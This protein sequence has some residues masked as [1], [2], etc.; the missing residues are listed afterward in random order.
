MLGPPTAITVIFFEAVWA[1]PL[2]IVIPNSPCGS[3]GEDRD[4]LEAPPPLTPP[5][6]EDEITKATAPELA[7]EYEDWASLL[8]M[9]LTLQ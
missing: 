5:P 3:T 8:S 4:S 9:A 1:S 6:A 2:F 7:V